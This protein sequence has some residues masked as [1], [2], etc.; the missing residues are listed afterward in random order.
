M[1]PHHF[2]PTT[3]N[4]DRAAEAALLVV[5]DDGYDAWLFHTIQHPDK[6]VHALPLTAH[7]HDHSSEGEEGHTH[8]VSSIDGNEHIWYDPSAV[9]EVASEI[10]DHINQ[11]NPDA[12]ASDDEVEDLVSDLDSRLHK[13]PELTYAQT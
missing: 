2:E 6:I 8:E 5:G 11:V 1:D 10:A 7:S 12:Q 3:P 13:L 4:Q 9:M